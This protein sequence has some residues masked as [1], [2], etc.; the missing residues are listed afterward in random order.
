MQSSG[1]FDRFRTD[2]STSQ[3]REPKN[4]KTAIKLY[5]ILLNRLKYIQLI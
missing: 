2:L 5:D 4:E 3:N 1:R